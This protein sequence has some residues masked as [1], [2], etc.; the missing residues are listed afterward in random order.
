VT[1]RFQPLLLVSLG[2]S[3]L[4]VGPS[5][6]TAALA[7][8]TRLGS[9][10]SIA[11]RPAASLD[12]AAAPLET[13][14][15]DLPAATAVPDVAPQPATSVELSVPGEMKTGTGDQ[16][17]FI[18]LSGGT[19][20]TPVSFYSKTLGLG[21]W[22]EIILPPGYKQSTQ[23]YPVLYLLHGA[24]GGA[25]EW[26]EV[27]IHQAADTLWT[28]GALPPFIIVLPEGGNGYYLNHAN[29]GPRWGDYIAGEVVQEIDANYR[30][31]ADPEHRAIGGL[32]MGGDGALQLGLHHPDI[33]GIVGA[34]SPTTRL[35]YDKLPGPFYGDT[36]YWLQ[37]NPVWL[38][39]NT[40]AA[41]ELKIWIDVGED[42]VWKPSAEA[43]HEALLERGVDHQFAELPGTHEAEYWE[44]NQD[45]YLAFY[46][47]A[48]AEQGL[49]GGPVHD[50]GT[51]PAGS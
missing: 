5:T 22:Y 14:V 6:S 3:L 41:A 10:S 8:V 37:N 40:D 33:F 45:D 2:L 13:V 24:A 17:T 46:G 4:A 11:A 29:G 25:S 36:D 20:V 1:R 18:A 12:V 50:P 43:L 9:A 38:I 34:H 7:R 39:E 15:A 27:G 44:A 42:D 31:L 16:P 47:G 51:A 21:T 32:S 26:V 30:T 49:A 28:E 35:S 48:F 23:R 19:T